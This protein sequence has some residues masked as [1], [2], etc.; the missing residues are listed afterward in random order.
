MATGT[1][2]KLTLMMDKTAKKVIFAEAEKDVVDILFNLLSL[3]IGT[4]IKLLKN[5]NTLGSIDNLYESLENMDASYLQP[6]HNKDQLLNT[7]VTAS[8]L[9]DPLLLLP[10]AGPRPKQRTLY[11][12]EKDR[13]VTDSK[14]ATSP[15]CSAIMNYQLWYVEFQNAKNVSGG[16]GG[17]VKQ[18]I[19]YLVTDDLC[20]K[21]VSM[22]SGVDLLQHSVKDIGASE[23][24]VVGFGVDEALE[25]LRTSLKLKASLSSVFLLKKEVYG[26]SLSN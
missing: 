26:V 22:I 16:E 21:P 11:K 3:P 20:V 23:K 5:E 17:V 4:V 1:K 10:E 9:C 8:V 15:N 12:C 25:L 7:N 24:K 6:N 19:T 13:H 14:H 18:L 2:V